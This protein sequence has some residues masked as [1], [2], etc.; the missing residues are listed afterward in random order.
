MSRKLHALDNGPHVR[1]RA[2]LPKVA[3][4][5]SPWPMPTLLPVEINLYGARDDAEKVGSI[6]SNTGT[7]L[8]FPQYGRENVEYYNPHFFRVEG[9]SDQVPAESLL[10][11]KQEQVETPNQGGEGEVQ[12]D[13]SAVVD[14]ILD[15]LSHHTILRDN[16]I[17]GQIKTV[18][19]P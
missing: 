5:T 16:P 12:G 13:A 3:A 2:Y 8:Q 4:E 19:K 6:L 11:C 15:S 17:D 14:S 10:P 7:F 18:L 1:L 9:F